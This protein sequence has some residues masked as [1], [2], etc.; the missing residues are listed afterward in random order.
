MGTGW[1][2]K[3]AAVQAPSGLGSRVQALLDDMVAEL[4]H[5]EAGSRLSAFNRAP[6]G[7]WHILPSRFFGILAAGIDLARE[8]GGAFDPTIGALV[9]LWGFGPTPPQLEPPS[10]TEITA[11]LARG[12]WQRIEIDP[13]G[14]RARQPGGLKLDLSAIAKGRAV[15][16]IALLLRGLGLRSFLVEVGGELLGQ[17]L[18][19]DGQPWWV[20]VESPPD[21]AATACR[22]ALHGLAIATSGDYRRYFYYGGRRYAHSLDPRTGRPVDNGIASVT[23]LHENCMQADALATAISVLGPEEGYAF[24]EAR[25][26]AAIIIV[27]NGHALR[28]VMTP[29]IVEMAH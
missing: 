13:I 16:E 4:S 1:S 21:A 22:V 6:A 10:N 28:E 17:G 19:P 29:L 9:D 2:V 27:R 12:G 7:S 11:A 3:L 26:I 23:V 20:E 14:C 5:W 25:G 8:T 15:D 24:A 18:R